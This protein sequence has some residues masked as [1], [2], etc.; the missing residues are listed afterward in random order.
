MEDHKTWRE[1][2]KVQEQ[3]TLV[4][5]RPF[6]SPARLPEERGGRE[7]R[8]KVTKEE[9]ER[10]KDEK[11]ERERRQQKKKAT[12]FRKIEKEKARVR[13]GERKEE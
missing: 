8:R 1:S 4:L 2:K 12:R 7:F 3:K 6:A 9:R 11:K 13:E 10:K 5:H